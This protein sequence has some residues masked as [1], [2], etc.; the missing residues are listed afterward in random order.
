MPQ[1]I[2]V[3]QLKN[4]ASVSE[5]L[6]TGRYFV[7]HLHQVEVHSRRD[8]EINFFFSFFVFFVVFFASKKRDEVAMVTGKKQM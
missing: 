3:W 8:R 2:S 7:L 4:Y 5:R 6:S 1:S